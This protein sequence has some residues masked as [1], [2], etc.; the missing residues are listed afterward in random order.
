V[1]ACKTSLQG[2]TAQSDVI[3]T[4][5]VAGIIT[6]NHKVQSFACRLWKCY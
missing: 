3:V 4:P 2:A 6:A 1:A 5:A